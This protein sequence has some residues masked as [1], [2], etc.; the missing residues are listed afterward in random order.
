MNQHD[1][2]QLI[3]STCASFGSQCKKFTGA[4]TTEVLRKY[5][6]GIGLNV[7]A[8]DTYIRTVPIEVDLMILRPGATGQLG[9]VYEPKD[10]LCA[11]E[12]KNN[13]A[14]GEQTT[15][16]IRKNFDAIRAANPFIQCAYVSIGEQC[17]YKHAVTSSGLGYPAFTLFTKR[18]VK[19][20]NVYTPTDA[21]SVFE[22]FIDVLG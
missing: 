12:V 15:P 8:R 19:G 22:A 10:I 21:W 16:S 14:Y 5:L 2:L 17:N 6:C 7:S 4:V 13:G 18:F 20:K 11:F 3:N 9:L 1:L